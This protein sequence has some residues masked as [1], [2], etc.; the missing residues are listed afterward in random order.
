[1]LGDAGVDDMGSSDTGSS[2]VGSSDAGGAGSDTGS[3]DTG[4]SDTG[5]IPSM[6]TAKVFGVET[7][8]N[9]DLHIETDSPIL[10]GETRR[11]TNANYIQIS[12]WP[13]LDNFRASDFEGDY[14][15]CRS[16]Q[17]DRRGAWGVIVRDNR[18][19]VMTTSVA[20]NL[21][22]ESQTETTLLG[23]FVFEGEVVRFEANYCE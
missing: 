9:F 16:N 5:G 11:I 10:C 22:I 2:D 7:R 19:Q 1:M 12:C 17:T 23:S 18:A 13:G 15:I 20:E 8:R 21:T 14:E 6:S 3:S 4:R